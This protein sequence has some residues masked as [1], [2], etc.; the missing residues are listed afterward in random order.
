MNK[1]QKE[2]LVLSL[3]SLLTTAMSVCISW[4]VLKEDTL[5]W[6]ETIKMSLVWSIGVFSV[7][8]IGIVIWIWPYRRNLPKQ[9]LSKEDKWGYIIS[10]FVLLN[11]SIF[12]MS[13]L[14][15]PSSKGL[16]LGASRTVFFGIGGFVFWIIVVIFLC[17]KEQEF[18]K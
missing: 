7:T 4:M 6:I 13:Y 14:E 11:L 2:A 9:L 18:V 10:I 3:P 8:A 12:M 1:L 5:I 17:F 15:E 16:L